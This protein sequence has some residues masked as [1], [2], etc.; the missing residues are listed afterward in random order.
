MREQLRPMEAQRSLGRDPAPN[1]GGTA[2]AGRAVPGRRRSAARGI[3]S[4]AS[5]STHPAWK[6]LHGEGGLVAG[7]PC[8]PGAHAGDRGVA[9]GS[10]SP[11]GAGPAPPL[12]WH[13]WSPQSL[14]VF[15]LGLGWSWLPAP[16]ALVSRAWEEENVNPRSGYRAVTVSSGNERG[17][18]CSV[19]P[20]ML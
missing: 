6:A 10:S 5:P 17:E 2:A 1:L 11:R 18:E 7:R 20:W 8:G 13:C 19:A 14:A 3:R 9:V 4:A 16:G 12:R 15:R